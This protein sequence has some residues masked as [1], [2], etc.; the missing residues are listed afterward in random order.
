ME[1]YSS[2]ATTSGGPGGDTDCTVGEYPEPAGADRDAYQRVY[3]DTNGSG[4]FESGG[5]DAE[6][7]T[8]KVGC[9]EYHEAHDHWH[10]QDF[11]QF[12]LETADGDP[13]DGIEPSRKIGFCIFD[14]QH[15]FPGPGSPASGF[16]SGSGCNGGDPG[17]GP[18]VMGL[19]SGWGDLYSAGLPGQ[20]LNITGINRGTYCL[21]LLANPPDP[22]EPPPFRSDIIEA[23]ADNN[24]RRKPIRINPSRDKAKILPGKC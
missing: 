6:R 11:A 4:F 8:D 19:S 5:A 12:R 3:E 14:N 16:Y 23:S 7:Y 18:E 1:L 22:A 20:R 21:A 13:I 17:T 15:S 2:A 10:L 24:D 9:F